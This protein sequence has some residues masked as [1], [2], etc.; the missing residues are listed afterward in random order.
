M[1]QRHWPLHPKPVEGEALSSWL[2]RIAAS[3]N[4]LLEDLLKYDLGYEISTD[5]LDLNPP[6]ILLD[7]IAHRSNLSFEQI[8]NM[9][10]KS[11]VPFII[12]YIDPIP[13]IFNTYML[14]YPVLLPAKERFSRILTNWRPWLSDPSIVRACQS[15]IKSEP[16][17]IIRLSWKL[18]IMLTCPFH[19]CRLQTCMSYSSEYV[20]WKEEETIDPPVTN[21]ILNM[22]TR[23]WQALVT[24]K[25]DLPLRSIHAG[26]WFRLLRS[27]LNELS[28]PLSSYPAH[29]NCIKHIWNTCE[30]PVRAG[31]NKWKPYESLPLQKQMQMLEAAATAISMIEEKSLSIFGEY[32]KLFQPEIIDENDLP[33]GFEPPH[34][35]NKYFGLSLNELLNQVITEAKVNRE[36]ARGLRTLYLYRG[37][38]PKLIKEVDTLFLELGI[39][40]KFS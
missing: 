13:D 36:T 5:E 38:D 10:F 8:H 15:C 26:V 39:P 2:G 34:T 33:S 20:Y 16:K 29:A 3:Y 27:L 11:W 7:S 31:L 12:D 22:D 14:Q 25:V 37:N 19:G 17:T 24:G 28:L 30:H 21:A 23:T 18:P 40:F 9:T 35:N 1:T 32:S 4:L 6:N